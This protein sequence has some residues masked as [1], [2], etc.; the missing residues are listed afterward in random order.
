MTLRWIWADEAGQMKLE[1]WVN[2]QGRLSI[3]KGELLCTTTPYTLNWLYNDFYEQWKSGNPDYLVVQ[4]RSCDNPYFPTEEYERVKAT[5]DSRTFR[6]R[7][8][9]LFEKMEGLVYED[10]I[11]AIHIIDPQELHF[12]EVLIGIDWG[13]TNETAIAVIGITADNS[14]YVI[15][16]YYKS[17]KVT[18]EIIERIK[19]FQKKYKVRFFY[20]DPAEPDRLE[21]MK[22]QGLFPREV[23]KNKD[24]VKR[25]IDEIRTLIKENRFHIF[26]TCRYTIDEISVYHYDAMVKEGQ[27]ES[28]DPVKEDDHMMDAIRMPIMMYHPTKVYVK[29]QSSYV[30]NNPTTGY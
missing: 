2:F 23:N 10:F 22:R 19:Y 21:E 14:Y 13:Y 9:G 15:D 20:P 26:R 6:R 1:A 28:E 7:Y 3:L 5:M 30:P 25:G 8:D 12:K 16:E 18:S 29:K 27:N 17:G 24:S 4:Y 11:P